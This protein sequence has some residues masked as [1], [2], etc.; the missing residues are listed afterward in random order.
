MQAWG[1]LP[2]QRVEF[3]TVGQ[4][5]GLP[6]A[7]D[8]AFG[9][10]P[11]P[12]VT[13]SQCEITL[14]FLYFSAPLPAMDDQ[15]RQLPNSFE[16]ML[17]INE[18]GNIIEKSPMKIL[19]PV[20]GSLCSLAAAHEVAQ[21]PWPKGSQVKVLYVAERPLISP[22]VAQT[23]PESVLS[24]LQSIACYPIEKALAQF[25]TSAGAPLA[26][27]SEI[28]PGNPRKVI[29]DV[30]EKWGADLIVLGSHGMSGIERF[31]PGSVSQAVALH[32][33]CSVEIVRP[34]CAGE[35]Q[36]TAPTV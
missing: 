28:L 3:L 24:R 33:K 13:V 35:R 9:K 12:T 11:Q 4:Q 16:K 32:A 25:D 1:F 7:T 27:E 22:Q 26:V 23:L 29:L 6:T 5:A 8:Q 21:R 31:L 17:S 18:E 30:A 19:L 10:I 34:R 14:M 20:D 36:D 2:N 15:A